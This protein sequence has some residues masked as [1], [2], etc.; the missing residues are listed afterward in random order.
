MPDMMIVLG[1]LLVDGF[2]DMDE[3]LNFYVDCS[4]MNGH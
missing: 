4:K 2:G 1:G 3:I